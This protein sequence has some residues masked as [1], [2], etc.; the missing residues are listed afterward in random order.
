MFPQKKLKR[1]YHNQLSPTE[2]DSD[3]KGFLEE[4]IPGLY[5]ATTNDHIYDQSSEEESPDNMAPNDADFYM[6][7]SISAG[8][9]YF[10][11]SKFKKVSYFESLNSI[12]MARM[13]TDSRKNTK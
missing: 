7:Y 1:P 9:G 4:Q 5:R 2:D 12:Y 11:M 8:P 6:N 3:I 10:T 13:R